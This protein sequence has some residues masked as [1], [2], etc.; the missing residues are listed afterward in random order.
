MTKRTASRT[1]NSS[2][3]IVS[4]SNVLVI[5]N[6]DLSHKTSISRSRSVPRKIV[7]S[8]KP[9]KTV[10]HKNRLLNTRMEAFDVTRKM[11]IG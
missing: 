1:P 5:A 9:N 6:L 7:F 8:K 11:T 10:T 4:A 2:R 3:N